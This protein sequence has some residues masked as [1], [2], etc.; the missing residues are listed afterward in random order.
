VRDKLRKILLGVAAL[1]ALGLGGAALS[2]A[3]AGSP[4]PAAREA[5]EAPDR[6][7][8][9][10]QTLSGEVAVRARAAALAET[11]GGTAG[12]VER[13]SEQG[14]A[15]DV[16]VTKTDGSKVDVRLD[17]RFAVVAVDSNADDHQGE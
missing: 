5:S 6:A 3:T 8:A 10:D 7:E 17:D 4:E 12:S 13:D 1:A 16:E 14:A 2:G 15:Y 9:P 11:G